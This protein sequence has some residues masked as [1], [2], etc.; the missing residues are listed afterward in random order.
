MSAG[1]YN[2]VIE[3]GATFRRV[4]EVRDNLGAVID[5]STSSLRAMVRSSFD[6]SLPLVSFTCS[7]DASGFIV[8]ELTA[9]QTA[10]LTQN[11]TNGLCNY[12][13]DLEVETGGTVERLLKGSVKVSPEATK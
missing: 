10:A 12:I 11:V 13:W 7:L 8:I 2:F 9:T 4:F 5:Y 6:A 1:V 3:Q